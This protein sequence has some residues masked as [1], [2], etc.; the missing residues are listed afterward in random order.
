MTENLNIYTLKDMR[1]KAGLTIREAAILLGKTERSISNWE[2]GEVTP[3][4]VTARKL[5][6]IYG[7]TLDALDTDAF[8]VSEQEKSRTH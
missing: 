8:Y 1:K 5:T 7:Y 4:V 6:E 2:T 3:S